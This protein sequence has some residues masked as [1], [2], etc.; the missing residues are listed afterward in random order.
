MTAQP[1]DA[2]LQEEA[3]RYL[4]SINEKRGEATT[5]RQEG[6]RKR[7][8]RE[9]LYKMSTVA[10]GIKEFS[11]D[12]ETSFTQAAISAIVESANIKNSI[13]A[14]IEQYGSPPGGELIDDTNYEE[15]AEEDEEIVGYVLKPQ[16]ASLFGTKDGF[17]DWMRNVY[18]KERPQLEQMVNFNYWRVKDGSYHFGTERSRA[19][20]MKA[21]KWLSWK[22]REKISAQGIQPNSV[23]FSKNSTIL[24]YD[25]GSHTLDRGRM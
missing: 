25:N 23:T 1:F 2:E 17:S 16:T 6:Q 8:L 20:K 11:D 19:A 21:R 18:L 5:A 4:Q 13:G 14:D 22:L 9:A 24:N 7:R 12:S 15:E 3:N 10:T